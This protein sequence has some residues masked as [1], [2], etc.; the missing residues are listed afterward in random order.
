M[1][2]TKLGGS[3]IETSALCLGCMNF[4]TRTP[5]QTSFALLDQFVDAGGTFLDTAN[6]YAFWVEGAQ[7]GESEALLGRWMQER[8]NRDRIVL[9]TK[10]GAMPTVPGGGFEHKEGLSTAAIIRAVE[11]S[12]SRLQTDHIDLYYAH[13]DDR[14]AP[15]ESTLEAFD[16]LVRAGKVRAIGCSNMMAWRIEQA[17]NLSRQREWASYCCVQQRYSY[18]RPKVGA[19]F[20][21]QESVSEELLAYCRV[22]DDLRLLAYSPLLSGVYTRQDVP[23]RAEYAGA[24]TEARLQT[25]AEVAREANMSPNQVVLAWLIQS[26][27]MALPIIAASNA[28]QLEESLQSMQLRLSIEQVERLTRAGA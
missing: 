21:V 6:N 5:E 13:I 28:E 11:G 24:D 15:L 1:N 9:A 16:Q 20:G 25:L 27:P 8:R 18:L 12:L 22:Y 23:M 19:D 3:G 14:D 26:S 7:G 4:G 2:N 17:R 10:V